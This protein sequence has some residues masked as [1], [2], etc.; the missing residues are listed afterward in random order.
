MKVFML[1][2]HSRRKLG[3][4]SEKGYNRIL[5]FFFACRWLRYFNLLLPDY[6]CIKLKHLHEFYNKKKYMKINSD[7]F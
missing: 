3:V 2:L 6:V 1:N 7:L 5:I 4:A